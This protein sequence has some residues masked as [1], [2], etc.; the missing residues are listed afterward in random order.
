MRTNA[1]SRFSRRFECWKMCMTCDSCTWGNG[2]CRS[3][4]ALSCWRISKCNIHK[5]IAT[6]G[7][8]FTIYLW[9]SNVWTGDASEVRLPTRSHVCPKQMHSG[10][11]LMLWFTYTH[12]HTHG[13][14]TRARF[15]LPCTLTLRSPPA[16][17]HL[18]RFY[19]VDS[20]VGFE[21]D[22]GVSGRNAIGF[23]C[24]SARSTSKK[25]NNITQQRHRTLSHVCVCLCVFHANLL[26]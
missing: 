5:Y 3:D 21:H 17:L 10:T 4:D 26:S 9:V 11:M 19:S 2:T 24:T 23:P 7:E 16:S 8:A 18:C 1:R 6:D 20:C 12:T 22:V 15:Q 14:T 13:V 25:L